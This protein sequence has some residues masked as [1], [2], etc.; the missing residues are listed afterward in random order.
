MRRMET[1][2]KRSSPFLP[3][4][5]AR[6]EKAK[7][8][9]RVKRVKRA[10]KRGKMKKAKMEKKV[11][12]EKKKRF[13]CFHLFDMH[14]LSRQIHSVASK[15]IVVEVAN[16]VDFAFPLFFAFELYTRETYQTRKDEKCFHRYLDEGKEK[17]SRKKTH[18]DCPC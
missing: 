1:Q 13:G 4:R 11:R 9:K 16:D 3:Q 12:T 8:V 15:K 17:C 2:T 18:E 5:Q 10:K 6:S 7:R 14:L